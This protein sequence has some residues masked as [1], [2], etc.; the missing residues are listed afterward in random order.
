MQFLHTKIHF[1]DIKHSFTVTTY[2]EQFK[3]ST[4]AVDKIVRGQSS[5]FQDL[6]EQR[7][8]V[9]WLFD[10]EVRT[11]VQQTESQVFPPWT[12]CLRSSPWEASKVFLRGCFH[13]SVCSYHKH[14]CIHWLYFMK[15]CISVKQQDIV[16]TLLCGLPLLCFSVNTAKRSSSA[17]QSPT[18]VAASERHHGGNQAVEVWDEWAAGSRRTLTIRAY[19]RET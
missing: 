18:S 6:M 5:S 4:P 12:L 14:F 17:A 19:V 1:H 13:V 9:P 3:C 8:S 11:T 10:C 15:T 7:L 16:D 2:I